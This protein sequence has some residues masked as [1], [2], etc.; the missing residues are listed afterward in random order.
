MEYPGRYPRDSRKRFSIRANVI[1]VC[2]SSGSARLSV[3]KCREDTSEL[4]PLTRS[5]KNGQVIISIRGIKNCSGVRISTR[6][7]EETINQN[8]SRNLNF[9]FFALPLFFSLFW[10][11]KV[12]K[13]RWRF[14][15]LR[16]PLRDLASKGLEPW[17]G[18]CDNRISI[19]RDSKLYINKRT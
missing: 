12:S 3:R 15:N 19:C 2:P 10:S 6:R 1:Q 13:N 14:V 8:D 4:S 16:L 17:N 18:L 5:R 11:R 9:L 7:R